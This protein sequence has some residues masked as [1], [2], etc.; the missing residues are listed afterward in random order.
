MHISVEV[1]PSI[2]TELRNPN[3]ENSRKSY[4]QFVSSGEI[5][6]AGKF[7]LLKP[8]SLFMNKIFVKYNYCL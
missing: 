4:W 8:T 7:L 3:D 2:V 5:K 6:D 1:D